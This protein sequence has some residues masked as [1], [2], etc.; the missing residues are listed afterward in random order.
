MSP[1]RT[2]A[3]ILGILFVLIGVVG[4]L[5]DPLVQACTDPSATGAVLGILPINPLLNVV[6]LAIGGALLYASM[7]TTSAIL[8]SRLIGAVLVAVGLLGFV[9]AGGFGLLPLGGGEIVLHLATG[10]VLLA[11]GVTSASERRAT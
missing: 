9:A 1:A 8:V 11:I 7:A 6:H 4:F 2:A 10:A 5:P 3:T